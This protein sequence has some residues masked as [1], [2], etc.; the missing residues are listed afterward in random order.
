MLVIADF[1]LNAGLNTGKINIQHRKA[2]ALELLE[3]H[4]LA[5]LAPQVDVPEP[6]EKKVKEVL[7]KED[8]I[9]DFN[10]VRKATVVEETEEISIFDEV[11][12]KQEK[13]LRI[14]E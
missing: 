5:S 13:Q 1:H 8:F 6:I 12:L 7:V 9:V 3:A 2:E 14:V 10:T 4:E 11:L